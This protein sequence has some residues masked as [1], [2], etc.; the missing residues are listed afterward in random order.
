MTIKP[1]S[2]LQMGV[3]NSCQNILRHLK[4]FHCRT[5]IDYDGAIFRCKST[6]LSTLRI[7]WRINS[8]GDFTFNYKGIRFES[9]Q[10]C[11]ISIISIF[12]CKPN[13][14]ATAFGRNANIIPFTI[15]ISWSNKRYGPIAG[16]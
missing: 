4:S 14:F 10:L 3:S 13:G 16:N 6:A 11:A 7:G 15:I 9:N 8:Q 5:I 12:K 1:K 2:N